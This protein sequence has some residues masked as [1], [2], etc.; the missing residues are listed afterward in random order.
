VWDVDA[1]KEKEDLKGHT[2]TV[3][4]VA[5]HPNGRLFASGAGDNSILVWKLPT[6]GQ[7]GK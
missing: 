5:F 4:A 7:A 6:A 3:Y 1:G 2:G